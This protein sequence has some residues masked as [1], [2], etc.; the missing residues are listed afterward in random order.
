MGL[1]IGQTAAREVPQTGWSRLH[2]VGLTQV[3]KMI[4][5]KA[6][7]EVNFEEG[8]YEGLAYAALHFAPCHVWAGYQQLHDRV[9]GVRQFPIPAL[10]IVK[11]SDHMIQSQGVDACKF[12]FAEGTVNRIRFN[13]YF[14][15]PENACSRFF[16]ASD[17]F[18][19]IWCL[20]T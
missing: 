14:Y 5:Q 19:N 20:S 9:Q 4:C 10:G 13:S 18:D 7:M 16:L 1:K 3:V 15:I 11:I 8:L 2:S 12:F 6:V 17:W